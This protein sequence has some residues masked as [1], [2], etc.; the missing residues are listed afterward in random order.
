MSNYIA[1]LPQE[2]RSGSAQDLNAFVRWFGTST[3]M[4]SITA[5]DLERYQ[6][7]LKAEARKDADQRLQSLRAFLTEAKK[8]K[9]TPTNLAVEIKVKRT[10]KKET[11]ESPKQTA[12]NGSTATDHPRL[13]REGYDKLSKELEYLET[14][15]RP[16]IALELKTA[17]ADKDFRENA[18]YDV[19]KNHQG[20]VEA[21]IR[22]LKSLL[23]TGE[24]VDEP[25][26]H[27]VADLGSKVTLFDMLEEEEI[28]YTL[29]GP[30]EIDPR[31]GKISIQSPV[32]RALTGVAVGDEVEVEVPA[33]TLRF[34]VQKIENR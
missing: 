15:M 17:A 16:K 11:A 33:G 8:Q 13:T 7:Q 23:E 30:G 22:D 18:P 31:H 6:E 27:D 4:D 20:E 14:V 24:V 19:A 29:V 10:K 26:N 5:P 3:Q 28:I 32:G 21:R 1:K 25:T 12:E 34:K 9:W 2:E